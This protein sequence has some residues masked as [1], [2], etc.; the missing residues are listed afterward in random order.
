[1]SITTEARE[2]SQEFGRRSPPQVATDTRLWLYNKLGEIQASL[3]DLIRVSIERAEA[4][5]DV[6]MPGFTHLQPAMTVRSPPNW[7]PP[8]PPPAA[9]RTTAAP[10]LPLAVPGRARDID[11]AERSCGRARSGVQIKPD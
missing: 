9:L 2:C 6:L 10:G 8:D 7:M 5:V 3:H 4:D 1:M 11:G